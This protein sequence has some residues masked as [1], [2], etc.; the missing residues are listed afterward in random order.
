M[1]INNSN[2]QR[3]S[4]ISLIANRIRTNKNYSRVQIA[5]DLNLYKSSVTN[6]VS[7]LLEN[8]I[9][10]EE[11]DSVNSGIG[12]KAKSL[13]LNSEVG[14]VV[15]IELTPNS[16]KLVVVNFLGEVIYTDTGELTQSN[17][18][19]MIDYVM[20]KTLQ[21]NLLLK[22]PILAVNFGIAGTIDT[23][24]GK[25][26]YFN[27]LDLKNFDLY[28]YGLK[29]YG[30][31]FY[32]DNDANCCA[33]YEIVKSKDLGD[34]LAIYTVNHRNEDFYKGIGI[35]LGIGLNS[36]VYSG[37]K[38]RVGEYLSY[39]WNQD[40]NC[41]NGLDKTVC[42]KA[43]TELKSF[44]I[45]FN[46]LCKSLIPILS[47]LDVQNV[48]FIGESFND[49]KDIKAMIK[50]DTPSLYSLLENENITIHIEKEDPFIV[51][52]GSALMFL[53]KLFNLPLLEEVKDRTYINWDDI[54]K[55]LRDQGVI[56]A[57]KE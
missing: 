50:E 25:I 40:I 53:Q 26:I 20:E 35:G 7:I 24:N 54:F 11:L 23:K 6:L 47:T 14:N 15:G 33:W 9:L 57:K 27:E 10:I 22:S 17:I 3:N 5:E 49:N 43:C 56:H 39:S 46:D 28:E 45:W 34:F 4:N 21:I 42:E 18:E 32:C 12:R 41:Q 36:S 29:Y 44:R 37:L 19:A 52:K 38:Y 31:P 48:F 2:F 55:I 1:S 8:N 13:K 51:A 30:I 16:Y